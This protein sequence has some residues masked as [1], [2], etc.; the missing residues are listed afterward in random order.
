MES[1]EIRV[2]EDITLRLHQEKTAPLLFS[3]IEENRTH[4]REWLPWLDFNTKIEDTQK[5]ISE[6]ESDYKKNIGLNLGIYFR[7]R[8]VGSVGFNVISSLNKSAEVGYML[9]KDYNGLGIMTKSCN[10]LVDYGFNELN[11]NRI[12]IKAGEQNYKSRAIPEKLD[13]NQEGILQQAEF[14]YDHY[15][16]M[17]VYAM[18]KENWEK[19]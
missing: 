3:L 15:V 4:F 7:D 17:V 19:K 6:C 5:F 1:F 9:G 8:L 12:V 2:D 14:L 11:L 13:F 10:A 16:N 18:L